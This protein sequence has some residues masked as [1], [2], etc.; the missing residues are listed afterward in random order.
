LDKEQQRQ[1]KYNMYVLNGFERNNLLYPNIIN[2][3]FMFN[4][5]KAE[6]MSMHNY[7]GLYLTENQFIKFNSITQSANNNAVISYYDT[8]NN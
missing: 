6:N 2:L 7:F 8:N 1:E 5:E 3:E 4:D